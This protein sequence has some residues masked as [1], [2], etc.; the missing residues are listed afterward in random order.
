MNNFGICLQTRYK[1]CC[2]IVSN[3]GVVSIAGA[4]KLPLLVAILQSLMNMLITT[5]IQ[6][7]IMLKTY[8]YIEQSCLK[9]KV[10]ESIIAAKTK[11]NKGCKTPLP[12]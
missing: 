3:K 4:V 7:W 1:A 10:N 12:L 9:L 11:T 6:L 5:L 8:F 2:F